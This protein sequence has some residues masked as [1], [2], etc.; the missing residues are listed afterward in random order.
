M[1]KLFIIDGAMR[2]AKNEL[3]R[4]LFKL[5]KNLSGGQRASVCLAGKL[6]TKDGGKDQDYTHEENLEKLIAGNEERW[7]SYTYEEEI[8]ALEKEKL[9]ELIKKHENIFLIVRNT[10]LVFEL[11]RKYERHT[12][13]VKV[14]TVYIY[15]DKKAIEDSYKTES[16]QGGISED[17]RKNRL[18][19]SDD[20]YESAMASDY[21]YDETLIYTKKDGI[22]SASLAVKINSLIHKYENIIEPYSIFFIQSF[23]D[24]DNNATNMYKNLQEAAKIAF[25]NEYRDECIGLIKGRGSYMIGETI[26][27]MIDSSD[28]IV[29][30]ITPDRCKD[31]A[32]PE[33]ADRSNLRVSPNIWLELGYTLFAMKSRNIKIGKKLLVTYKQT[34]GSKIPLL[35]TDICDVN[36]IT[37]KNN[38]DFVKQVSTHLGD[39]VKSS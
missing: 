16:K 15:S 21:S 10:D 9:D 25:K 31:C 27:E 37:Y 23:S 28:F 24:D 2:P 5:E 18:K 26:W 22:G 35:P 30:D 29:C 32:I 19:L 1:R 20:D 34:D 7:I 8:Y 13:P 4:H 14:I 38:K 33:T 11:K 17:E 3:V 36:V 6:C 39:L 12:I